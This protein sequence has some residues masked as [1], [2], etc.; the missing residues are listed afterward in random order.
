[1]AQTLTLE[2]TAV[3]RETRRAAEIVFVA[4]EALRLVDIRTPD[5]VTEVLAYDWE[6]RFA[7]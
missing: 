6:S 4:A 5:D 2:T 7:R 1:M 3:Q